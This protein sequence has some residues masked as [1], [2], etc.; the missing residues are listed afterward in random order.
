M[1]LCGYSFVARGA[2][3]A[4]EGG[5]FVDVLIFVPVAEGGWCEGCGWRGGRC[6]A[7]GDPEDAWGHFGENVV[8]SF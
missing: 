4:R 1:R 3:D 6:D 8:G 2:R 7:G 5:D